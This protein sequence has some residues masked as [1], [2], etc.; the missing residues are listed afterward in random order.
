M[1]FIKYEPDVK[2]PKPSADVKIGKLGISLKKTALEPYGLSSASY[3]SLFFDPDTGSV[4]ISPA[5]H[6]EKGAF[7]ATP[8]GKGGENVFVA[9]GKFYAKFGIDLHQK[10]LTSTL[11]HEDGMA[12]FTIPGIKAGGSAP[13]V[14]YAGAKR[15]RKPKVAA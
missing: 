6:D 12:A 1:A 8:R 5:S 15:G 11:R 10:G 4:G 2:P 14:P 9:A 13:T 7:K 3:V